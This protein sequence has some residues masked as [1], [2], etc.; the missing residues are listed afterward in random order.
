MLAGAILGSV[1]YQPMSLP[2]HSVDVS[3][4]LRIPSS[5]GHS[6]H[7][8]PSAVEESRPAK[9]II[10]S[11]K[12]STEPKRHPVNKAAVEVNAKE[13]AEL[14]DSV[15]NDPQNH[16]RTLNTLKKE[17]VELSRSPTANRVAA[18]RPSSPSIGRYE[19]LVQRQADVISWYQQHQVHKNTMDP[20]QNTAPSSPNELFVSILRGYES[21]LGESERA[22][23]TALQHAREM[24]EE[25]T[26]SRN[27]TQAQKGTVSTP[28]NDEFAKTNNHESNGKCR[29]CEAMK[30]SLDLRQEEN[31][32]LSNELAKK[33]TNISKEAAKLSAENASLRDLSRSQSETISTLHSTLQALEDQ[34]NELV[35]RFQSLSQK[36]QK[37]RNLEKRRMNELASRVKELTELY[38]WSLDEVKGVLQDFGLDQTI[39]DDPG[40]H[41]K[42]M[43]RIRV[44]ALLK[45]NQDL[46]VRFEEKSRECSKISRSYSVQSQQ[47]LL[48]QSKTDVEIDCLRTQL[49]NALESIDGAKL[50]RERAVKEAQR[51]Q[52]EVVVDT[53]KLKHELLRK[54][55]ELADLSQR[56]AE[57]LSMLREQHEL[58]RQRMIKDLE[59]AQKSKIE[60]QIEIGHLTREKR[61]LETELT[62]SKR[63][64]GTTEQFAR[65]LL[66]IRTLASPG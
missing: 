35:S 53:E 62:H 47:A 1:T 5:R 46:R 60:L 59:E 15:K 50:E 8:L 29:E 58:D 21:R 24:Q 49:R 11:E 57:K 65:D 22:L 64:D 33:H 55:A 18:R 13:R 56:S 19:E 14:L 17:I 66:H 30:S 32:R 34:H 42:G 38:Q 16:S 52:R 48:N 20:Q 7:P 40:S 6:F 10:A 44:K 41:L 12:Q 31:L 63:R 28:D 25:K 4:D 36:N 37:Q 2:S 61:S 26:T 45:E 51:I 9:C 27:I 3:A 23:A 54:E 43:A 39:I